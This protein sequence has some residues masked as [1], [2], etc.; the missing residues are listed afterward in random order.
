MEVCERVADWYSR[1]AQFLGVV[2]RS[3]K[4]ETR[5]G[6]CEEECEGTH[7]HIGKPKV[8]WKFLVRGSSA[9][10]L[11]VGACASERA[12]VLLENGVILI[13]D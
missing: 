4:C 1:G 9:D 13:D 8:V 11:E 12:Q 6:K 10:L 2:G 3:D 5:R 7:L